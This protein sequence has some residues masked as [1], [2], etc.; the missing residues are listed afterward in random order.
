MLLVWISCG[1]NASVLLSSFGCLQL[2]EFLVVLDAVVANRSATVVHNHSHVPSLTHSP[3]SL[4]G[5]HCSPPFSPARPG[6][7]GR[8]WMHACDRYAFSSDSSLA[9]SLARRSLPCD[10][11]GTGVSY[12]PRC[13]DV[14]NCMISWRVASRAELP[15]QYRFVAR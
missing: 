7:D 3:T 6:T 11:P 4:S 12:R 15:R 1:C 9:R 14:V 13:D 5:F 10:E 2:V 8:E